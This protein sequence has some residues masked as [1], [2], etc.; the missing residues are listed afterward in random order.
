MSIRHFDD[1]FEFQATCPFRDCPAHQQGVVFH[2]QAEYQKH[3]SLNHERRD[4][5]R[6][7]LIWIC[8]ECGKNCSSFYNFSAH[9]STH[10]DVCQPPWICTLPAVKLNDTKYVG[11]DFAVGVCGKRSSTKNN[12]KSHIVS[13]HKVKFTKTKPTKT[14]KG[15]SKS[16]ESNCCPVLC[17]GRASQG[18]HFANHPF[19]SGDQLSHDARRD[20]S[21][22]PLSIKFT[23]S[24][25][26]SDQTVAATRH[27]PLRAGT[28]S[29]YPYRPTHY[30]QKPPSLRS[31]CSRSSTSTVPAY[32]V[33]NSPCSSSVSSN[34]ISSIG[35][36]GDWHSLR[37]LDRG[38][39]SPVSPCLCLQSQ[40]GSSVS[41][42]QLQSLSKQIAS[43]RTTTS[44]M[45]KSES[46]TSFSDSKSI[47]PATNGM[48]NGIAAESPALLSTEDIAKLKNLM[49]CLESDESEG[50]DLETL[51]ECIEMVKWI[52]FQE[53][54]KE[55]QEMFNY[56]QDELG[57][58]AT[59]SSG[60]SH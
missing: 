17:H 8:P 5:F 32:T 45:D 37:V 26:H 51:M 41:S 28:A 19:G 2:S 48:R 38:S 6:N 31:F 36:Q 43:T 12:L 57:R 44:S 30:L 1:C 34:S 27:N 50:V 42:D 11:F 55:L 15:I 25:S 21:I 16:I 40:C 35:S 24:Y 60:S 59:T 47:N 54:S 46:K 14:E 58:H 53:N 29:L 10:R 22:K 3:H 9:V 33:P 13:V 4:K 39:S 20:T 18:S 7:N 52:Q 23:S 49:S 56:L